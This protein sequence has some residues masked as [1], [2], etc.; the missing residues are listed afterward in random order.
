MSSVNKNMVYLR[1]VKL[2]VVYKFLLKIVKLQ[3]IIQQDQIL[4]VNNVNK[5][6]IWILMEF[7]NQYLLN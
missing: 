7:V 1:W 4:N 3:I 6:F 5:N 2:L